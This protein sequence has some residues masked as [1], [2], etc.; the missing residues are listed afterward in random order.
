M[1]KKHTVP[2]ELLQLNGQHK[3]S[4]RRALYFALAGIKSLFSDLKFGIAIIL[5]L[6]GIRMGLSAICKFSIGMVLCVTAGVLTV[7]TLTSVLRRHKNQL[8]HQQY[9]AF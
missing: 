6:V 1:E 2:L 8:N 7:S 9:A 3:S 4:G 5:V